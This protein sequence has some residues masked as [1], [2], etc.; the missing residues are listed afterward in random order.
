MFDTDNLLKFM[1]GTMKNEKKIFNNYQNFITSPRKTQYCKDLFA[2]E[3]AD[4][5]AVF[6]QSLDAWELLLLSLVDV[7]REILKKKL[8][9]Y[10]NTRSHPSTHEE[11]IENFNQVKIALE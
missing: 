4:D 10:R 2:Y 3:Y 8:I 11:S 1:Q 5:N 6:Q 7:D 9:F